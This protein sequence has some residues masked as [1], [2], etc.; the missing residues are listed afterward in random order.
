MSLRDSETFVTITAFCSMAAAPGG[1]LIVITMRF[2]FESRNADCL[3]NDNIF[4]CLLLA[5]PK[6][7]ESLT[8]FSFHDETAGE[9][10]SGRLPGE[11]Q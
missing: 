1:D 11:A 5:I 8:Y 4:G 7:E 2:G 10:G 3:P 9:A 6:T